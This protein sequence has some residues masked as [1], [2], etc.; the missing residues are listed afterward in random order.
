MQSLTVSKPQDVE[1]WR[2]QTLRHLQPWIEGL[3][4]EVSVVQERRP[5]LAAQDPVNTGHLGNRFINK[6]GRY[7]HKAGFKAVN[8]LQRC[9]CSPGKARVGEVVG[10]AHC[11]V[12]EISKAVVAP[13]RAPVA[14]EAPVVVGD[15][16]SSHGLEEG[17]IQ[18]TEH[19]QP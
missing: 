19:L 1:A 5:V 16:S 14:I 9:R 10:R 11:Q 8:H 2:V 6:D 4:P 18:V 12:D 15:E 13:L 3:P 17:G 7:E